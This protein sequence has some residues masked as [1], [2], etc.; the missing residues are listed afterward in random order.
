MPKL[1]FS[2][3]ILNNDIIGFYESPLRLKS[4]RLS[5]FYVN[6]RKASNDAFLL[7]QLSDFL[8][9]FI[10]DNGL[11]YDSLYGVPEGASKTAVITALKLAK[12]SPKFGPGSHTIAMGRAQAKPHGDPADRYFI[13]QPQGRTLVLEDTITTG[14]SLFQCLDKLLETGI[15]VR[16]VICLTDRCERRDDGKTAAEHLQEKYSGRISY[17]ALSRAPDLLQIAVKRRNASPNLI[18]A[19]ALELDLPVKDFLA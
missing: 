18:Q 2:D 4:G 17:H 7:D 12:A 6:W 11:E 8:V 1:E 16:G 13:G 5:H 3:Y 10:L 9:Q 15:D 14:L 19:L